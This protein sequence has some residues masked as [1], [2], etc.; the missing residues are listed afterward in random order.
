MDILDRDYVNFS[1]I[2]VIGLLHYVEIKFHTQQDGLIKSMNLCW[3]F[4]VKRD[5]LEN[6]FRTN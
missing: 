3:R 2:K 4:K 5:S 1:M 6:L